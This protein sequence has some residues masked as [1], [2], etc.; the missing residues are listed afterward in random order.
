MTPESEPAERAGTLG[1]DLPISEAANSDP[2]VVVFVPVGGSVVP[3]GRRMAQV[4]RYA[5]RAQGMKALSVQSVVPQV[6]KV[7][8]KRPKRVKAAG[9]G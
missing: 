4:L 3:V 9:P 8:G 6:V 1:S 2:W 5:L 7:K